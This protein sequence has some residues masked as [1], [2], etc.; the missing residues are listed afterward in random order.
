MQMAMQQGGVWKEWHQVGL[1]RPHCVG[2]QEPPVQRVAFGV[3]GTAL[4]SKIGV[5]H[6]SSDT[7]PSIFPS[8]SHDGRMTPS[9]PVRGQLYE[10]GKKTGQLEVEFRVQAGQQG[11][12]M[13]QPQGQPMQVATNLDVTFLP[14]ALFPSGRS[15]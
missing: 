8:A 2:A 15:I 9:P 10:N 5:S 4:P 6:P 7:V 3:F 1:P 14:A 11:G 13:G 12:T